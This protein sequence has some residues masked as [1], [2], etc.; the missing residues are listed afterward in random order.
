MNSITLNGVSKQYQD[1][2][3][4]NVSFCVPE[5]SIVGLIGENGAGKT[6]TLKLILNMIRADSGSI[7]IFGQDSVKDEREVKAKIGAVLEGDCFYETLK[8]KDIAAILRNV[9]HTWDDALF[10][11]LRTRFGLPA[12]KPLKDFSQGMKMKLSIAA[13]LSHRP[14]LLILDEATSGLDPVVR[15]EILEVF[16]D[17]IQDEKHAILLS[18]HIT[19]DLE[20]VADY[21][22]F[23]HEGRLVLFENKDKL[24]YEYG[25]LKCG[26]EAFAHIAPEDAV[27]WRRSEYGYEVLTADKEAAARKYPELV[28]D[29]PALEDIMLLMIKGERK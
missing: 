3:L 7:E 24:L 29:S 18:S 16:L 23:L 10:Q 14:K 17:F 9:F 13:A 6:T 4:Q 27:C 22:A 26:G 21:I 20:K 1:F 5:G 15:S 28:L 12:D 19:S 11:S 2:A 25:I 8:C